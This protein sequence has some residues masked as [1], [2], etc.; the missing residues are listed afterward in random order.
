M[1]LQRLPA[2]LQA[3][4]Q[5]TS[6]LPAGRALVQLVLFLLPLSFWPVRSGHSWLSHPGLELHLVSVSSME[7]DVDNILTVMRSVP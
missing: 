4:G 1:S 3:L 6:C 2:L 5:R 7:G